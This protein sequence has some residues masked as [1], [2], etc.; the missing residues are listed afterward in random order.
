MRNAISLVGL[1]C[2][3]GLADAFGQSVEIFEK[4]EGIS[5]EKAIPANERGI[6]CLA[7]S[8]TGR[9]Y[10]GTTGR[11][12]H[13]FVCDP[14]MGEVRSLARLDG[15]IGF[16]YVLIHCDDG[17]LIAGTQ[18][19]PT[20]IARKTDPEA[21]G[22]LYRF[23]VGAKGEAKVEDLGV[24][25]QGQGIYTLAYS[26][27]SKQIVGNTWPDGHFFS[28]DME[29]RTFK[30]H[31]AIAGYHTFETP[32]HA[33]D[34]NRGTDEK[35]RYP[36][37]V[38]RTIAIVTARPTPEE[39]TV[40]CIVMIFNPN[41]WRS[42]LSVFQL[43]LVEN[44]GMGLMPRSSIGELMVRMTTIAHWWAVLRT[45]IFLNYVSL[46]GST[47]NCDRAVSRFPLE[48]SRRW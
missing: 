17:S 9:I 15:G 30:D 36:R 37:H 31:G 7:M 25:I 22:H 24:P 10:G 5:L 28:F 3:L 33:D 12:A 19:D 38:S 1:I 13:L 47:W 42:F 41:G 8:P 35:I 48:P 43:F 46:T 39:P 27:Q 45:V 14:V 2:C 26:A 29:T 21:V 40:T 20:G 11:A 16:S 4:G 34:L 23:I 6:L 32:R 44:L 18:A